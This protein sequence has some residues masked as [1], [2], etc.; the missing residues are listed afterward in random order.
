MRIIAVDQTD[1]VL[2]VAYRWANSVFEQPRLLIDGATLPLSN[3]RRVLERDHF[4]G[5]VS[6]S[7]YLVV[8]LVTNQA[9]LVAV[10]A[11]FTGLEVIGIKPDSQQLV[12]LAQ[13]LDSADRPA[14]RVLAVT[15]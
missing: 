7:E 13:W 12:D 11:A 14:D 9:D 5:P 4:G 6:A 15:F 8:A 2:R 10:Q 1:G 3:L